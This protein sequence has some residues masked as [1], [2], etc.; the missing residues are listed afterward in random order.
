MSR[1]SS[2]P[3]AKASALCSCLLD[4]VQ[5]TAYEFASILRI[6]A[7]AR[8]MISPLKQNLTILFVSPNLIVVT[9]VVIFDIFNTLISVNEGFFTT[10]LLVVKIFWFLGLTI[11]F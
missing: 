2:A 6:A 5:I 11:V 8:R 3:S 10:V 4:L 1:P 7:H 9:L